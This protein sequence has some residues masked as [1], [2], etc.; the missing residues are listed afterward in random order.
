MLLIQSSLG[1]ATNTLDEQQLVT[2]L[3]GGMEQH[4]LV[5]GSAVE[6]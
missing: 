2:L 5:L 1:T 3:Q 4:G 6:N